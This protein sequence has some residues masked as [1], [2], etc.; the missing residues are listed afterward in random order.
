MKDEI[1]SQLRTTMR[2]VRVP[3]EGPYRRKVIQYLNEI[4]VLYAEEYWTEL[5]PEMV[6]SKFTIPV[7]II[8]NGT[9]NLE[10]SKEDLLTRF[11]ELSGIKF[12]P[13]AVQLLLLGTSLLCEC[14]F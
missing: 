14:L 8:L 10:I 4:F 9:L 7:E 13:N 5:L 1:K 2:R 6:S 12:A 3:S 11:Q